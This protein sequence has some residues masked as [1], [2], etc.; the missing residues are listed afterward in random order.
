VVQNYGDKQ[1][2][3][4][5]DSTE[6]EDQQTLK[7]TSNLK[8]KSSHPKELI[9]GNIDEGIRT[10]SKRRE[11]SSALALVSEIELKSIEEILFDES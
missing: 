3:E 9:V 2:A 6:A 1:Q 11:E 7:P 10:R 8:H 4:L 5:E